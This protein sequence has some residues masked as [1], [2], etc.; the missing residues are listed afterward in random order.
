MLRRIHIRNI[1]LITEQAIEFDD[2]FSVLTGETGAGK[3]IIIESFNFVLGERASRELIKYGAQKA[4]AEAVFVILETEPAAAILRE[5]ELYPEDGELVLYRELSQTGK[6]V[7][8]V[9]GTLVG[10]AMLKQIGDALID[11]HGQ[12]AHQSLLDPKKHLAL[13]DQFAGAETLRLKQ[14]TAEAY[15]AYTE[16][17]RALDGSVM[18]ERE[19]AQ[20][21]DLYSYQLQ[22]IE[23]AEL[24]D[25][26]EEEL[27]DERKKLQNA[28]QIMEALAAGTEGLSGEMGALTALTET[29]RQLNG[30]RSY[31]EEYETLADKLQE[32]YYA[33]EDA[34]YT[35]RDLRDGFSYDPQSLDSIEWRL[36]LISQLKRKYGANIAE[37]LAYAEKIGEE[38]QQ[39]LTIEERRDQMQADYERAKERYLDVAGKLSKERHAAAARLK[40]ALLPELSDLGM[41]GAAFEVQIERMNGEAPSA[42]GYDA[43]EFLLSANRGEP[44]KAL[45]RVAS[46]GELSRIMLAFKTVLAAVDGIPTMVFDEIDTGISGKIGTVV[47]EKMSEIAK[48][49]Q[50]LCVTHLAQIAAYADAHYLIEK[51]TEDEHTRSSTVRLDADGHCR[52]VAR[53]MGGETDDGVALLHARRLIEEA[54]KKKSSVNTR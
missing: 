46:G 24:R 30:I 21:C 20:K 14:E 19:R 45:A 7:C 26:E 43:V 32:S 31:G 16:A 1:A 29:L 36:E 54:E 4:S 28:Q 37:I 3:S 50:V 2:G 47:A 6:N 51:Q 27:L 33:V 34:A 23:K 48:R 10:T 12:H 35:L 38:Y 9:N 52:E 39:L 25:G 18:N 40:A 53:I 8:R 11:I 5:M 17:K 13:L 15:H 44:I 41:P 42:T 22:E 49:H